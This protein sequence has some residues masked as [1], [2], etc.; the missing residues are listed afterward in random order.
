[1]F[2]I[3]FGLTFFN[4]TDQFYFNSLVLKLFHFSFFCFTAMLCAFSSQKGTIPRIVNHTPQVHVY[5][6]FQ[7]PMTNN[8]PSATTVHRKKILNNKTAHVMSKL[9]K[10]QTRPVN[11]GLASNSNPDR[12]YVFKVVSLYQC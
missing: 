9:F 10:T 11:S 8:N 2:R 7:I 4:R 1:M 3:S 5:H 12:D 6:L